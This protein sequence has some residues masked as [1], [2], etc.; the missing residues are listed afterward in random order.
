MRTVIALDRG[1]V[2]AAGVSPGGSVVRSVI[3]LTGS[4]A[5]LYAEVG[6]TVAHRR[7]RGRARR[8]ERWRSLRD[9]PGACP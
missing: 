4:K 3:K 9:R 7:R 6:M 5:E 1:P 2:R 8:I